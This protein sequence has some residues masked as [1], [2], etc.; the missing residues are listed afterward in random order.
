MKP[1]V[2]I[3]SKGDSLFS[4]SLLLIL[5]DLVVVESVV[6]KLLDTSLFSDASKLKSVVFP[7]LCNLLTRQ[8]AF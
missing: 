3:R 6:N 5:N 7:S 8:L 4:F 1:T 2:S